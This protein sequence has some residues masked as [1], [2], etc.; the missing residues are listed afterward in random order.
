MLQWPNQD[1]LTGGFSFDVGMHVQVLGVLCLGS[2]RSIL[3]GHVLY[4]FRL[5][6]WTCLHL[7]VTM[8]CVCRLA[9]TSVSIRLHHA[10][11]GLR[12]L[13]QIVLRQETEHVPANV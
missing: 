6:L 9:K 11:S 13:M 2:V 5:M 3:D 4:V 7:D 8:I 10:V 12:M 1:T